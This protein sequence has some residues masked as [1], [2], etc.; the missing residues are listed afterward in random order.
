MHLRAAVHSQLQGT[1][2]R[3]L[4]LRALNLH[5][6]TPSAVPWFLLNL[7]HFFALSLS[8]AGFSTLKACLSATTISRLM[9]LFAAFEAS[10]NAILPAL[11]PVTL[12]RVLLALRQ[13][14]AI[15]FA[16]VR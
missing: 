5:R 14:L 6:K 7:M 13:A 2:L 10:Q 4:D 16:L 11:L 8:M 9:P 12:A 1:L 15:S 3:L